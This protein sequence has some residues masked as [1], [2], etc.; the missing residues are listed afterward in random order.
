MMVKIEN[1]VF[2]VMTPYI[3]AGGYQNFH[4]QGKRRAASFFEMLVVTHG[5][6]HQ[7]TTICNSLEILFV[8]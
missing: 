3:L 1:V 2:W 7:K 6:I 4:L 5:V 8:L